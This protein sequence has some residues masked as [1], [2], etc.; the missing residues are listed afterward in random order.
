VLDFGACGGVESPAGGGG[1]EGLGV[2][3]RDDAPGAAADVQ[4][5]GG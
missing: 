1:R 4:G 3:F 5:T 2:G